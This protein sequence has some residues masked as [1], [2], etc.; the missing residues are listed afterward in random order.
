MDTLNSSILLSWKLI[1]LIERQLK[2]N[3]KER[4]VRTIPKSVTEHEHKVLL[5][6]IEFK[7]HS[8]VNFI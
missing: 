4:S 1:R 6:I 3:H 7:V 2:K 5:L 8:I